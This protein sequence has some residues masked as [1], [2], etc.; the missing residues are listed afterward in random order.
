M[1]TC[2][3]VT[4][5]NV[6]FLHF[7][8]NIIKSQSFCSNLREDALSFLE[9]ASVHCLPQCILLKVRPSKM[10]ECKRRTEWHFNALF[11]VERDS[12]VVLMKAISVHITK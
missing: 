8:P 7:A 3:C 2:A 9:E 11:C 5:N 1:S 12:R 4:Y 6:N 10:E